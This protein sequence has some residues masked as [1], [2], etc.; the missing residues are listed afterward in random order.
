MSEQIQK[1]SQQPVPNRIKA[2]EGAIKKKPLWK[3]VKETFFAETARSV[4]IYLWK[5]IMLPAIKKLVD[6]A[7]ANAIH[8]AI[9]GEQKPLR[10]NQSSYP[11]QSSIYTGRSL[12]QRSYNRS[13]HYQSIMANCPPCDKELLEDIMD[14]VIGTIA[15]YGKISVETLSQILPVELTFDTVHTDRNWGWT[16]LNHNCIVPVPGGYI[17][18]LPP[19]KPLQ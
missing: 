11:I 16:N 13:N 12:M 2:K 6:D 14:E 17:L 3:R 15:T 18:D 7:G 4:G 9:Y 1:P 10:P 8:M 19:A 5:D